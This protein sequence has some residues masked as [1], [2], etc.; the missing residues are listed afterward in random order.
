M[1]ETTQGHRRPDDSEPTD[2]EA[3]EYMKLPNGDWFMCLPNGLFGTVSPKVHT[4]TEHDDGSI[5]VSPSI[6]TTVPGDAARSWHGFLERGVWRS[7]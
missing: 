7:A 6:L 2:L 1:A 3:G 4:V 5:S